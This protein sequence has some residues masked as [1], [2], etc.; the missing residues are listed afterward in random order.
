[1]IVTSSFGPSGLSSPFLPANLI[2]KVKPLSAVS[3]VYSPLSFFKLS[4]YAIAS[5]FALSYS[6][7][8]DLAIVLPSAKLML[9]LITTSF[10][11]SLPAYLTLIVLPPSANSA[12]YSPYCPLSIS[13]YAYASDVAFAAVPSNFADCSL[14]SG[15]IRLSVIVT[16]SSPAGCVSFVGAGAAGASS[17]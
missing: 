8:Y 15:R 17:A 14:P 12:L 4:A 13:A 7:T 9:T 10:G 2:F 1:M 16:F 11:S 6:P 5:A 3:T